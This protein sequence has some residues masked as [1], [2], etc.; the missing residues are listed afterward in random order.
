MEKSKLTLRS[1]ARV[2]PL[3]RVNTEDGT[4][5]WEMVSSILHICKCGKA[6]K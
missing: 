3:K 2:I 6:R 5:F 4:G 1:L